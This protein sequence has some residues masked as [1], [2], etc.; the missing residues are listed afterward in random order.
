MISETNKKLRNLAPQNKSITQD[1]EIRHNIQSHL[2]NS[3]QDITMDFRKKQK[4]FSE[5]LSRMESNATTTFPSFDFE[6]NSRT[7]NPLQDSLM[8]SQ[9]RTNN[10]DWSERRAEEY[11][12]EIQSIHTSVRELAEITKDLATLVSD[13]GTVLDRIDCNIEKAVDETK[14][15]LNVLEDTKINQKRSLSKR[16]VIYLG[17]A[18][19]VMLFLLILKTILVKALKF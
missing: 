6:N 13:Q 1:A 16:L 12:R 8:M 3:L 7:E 15:A 11:E 10:L 5:K 18:I 17:I 4:T 14:R 19:I 2:A 9:R